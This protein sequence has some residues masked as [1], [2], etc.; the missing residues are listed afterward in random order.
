MPQIQNAAFHA[1]SHVIDMLDDATIRE[2]VFPKAK[3]IF[4]S[5]P[6]VPVQS[7]TLNCIERIVDNL[8][9]EEILDHV[10]PI[11][12]SAKLEE[13]LVL[14]PV[15][16]IYKRMMQD[17]RFGLTV[18]ILA[19]KIMPTLT[20]VIVSPKL[21]MEEVSSELRVALVTY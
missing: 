19:T 2:T 7:N 15:I 17:K 6:S 10:L 13:P 12:L 8:E 11:L 16:R 21:R 18:S 3:Q 5:N 4:E 9:K 1:I 20:P 14:L